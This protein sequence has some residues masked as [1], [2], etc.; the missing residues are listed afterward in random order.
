MRNRVKPVGH[1]LI[2]DDDPLVRRAMRRALFGRGWIADEAATT[3]EALKLLETT[4][5]AAVLTDW[6]RP[7]DSGAATVRAVRGRSPVVAYT[8]SPGL[9]PVQQLM[10]VV[11]AVV[12]KPASAHELD[13]TLR[14]AVRH[15]EVHHAS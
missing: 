13:L 2:V 10:D 7:N 9:V 15:W 8:G 11:V 12:T 6:T 4:A 5:Y 1:L 3:T 14:W